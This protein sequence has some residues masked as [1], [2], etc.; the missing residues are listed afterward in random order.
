MSQTHPDMRVPYVRNNSAQ[1]ANVNSGWFLEKTQTN[2]HKAFFYIKCVCNVWFTFEILVSAPLKSRISKGIPFHFHLIFPSFAL[3]Y[4]MQITNIGHFG[5]A[6]FKLFTR[7]YS[8]M[9]PKRTFKYFLYK[10][11]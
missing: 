2:A 11:I 3:F 8:K 10:R 5:I 6:G 9:L 1:T 4:I 7:E